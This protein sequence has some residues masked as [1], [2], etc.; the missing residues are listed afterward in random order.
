MALR[1]AAKESRKTFVLFAFLII[2]GLGLIAAAIK[3]SPRGERIVQAASASRTPAA[4]ANK[5]EAEF[6]K[7]N[8]YY[9]LARP[10]RNKLTA[11]VRN[12]C[13]VKYQAANCVYYLTKCG[14]PCLADLTEKEQMRVLADY[15][16]LRV[17]YGLGPLTESR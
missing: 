17:Q 9:E 8:S 5:P 16:R 12:V 2:S 10:V 14:R 13:S 3:S 1:G 15:K 7:P 4:T 11:T 6:I